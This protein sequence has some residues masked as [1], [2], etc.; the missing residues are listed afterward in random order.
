[1]I[2]FIKSY[3]G[4]SIDI[5]FAPIEREFSVPVFMNPTDTGLGLHDADGSLTQSVT[6]QHHNLV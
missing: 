4:S 1:M 5:C 6:N 2:L 3:A